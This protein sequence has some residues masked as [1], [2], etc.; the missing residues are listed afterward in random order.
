MDGTLIDSEN[1][2]LSTLGMVIEE[3][4]G[5]KKSHA[6]LSLSLGI[7]DTETLKMFGIK[8]IEQVKIKWENYLNEQNHKLVLFNGIISLLEELNNRDLNLG[9]VTSRTK[10]ALT[11]LLDKLELNQ[12]FEKIVCMDDTRKHKPEADPMLK[13]L[14]IAEADPM[15]VIYIGDTRYDS[16][17]AKA[18]NVDFGLALWG[19]KSSHDVDADYIFRGPPDILD[20]FLL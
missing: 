4:L 17:C 5:I 3:E 6:E 11:I 9:I 19:A 14:E 12:Y 15:D 20:L 8:N 18:A 13:Y 1:V 2:I 16:M 7:P 10:K